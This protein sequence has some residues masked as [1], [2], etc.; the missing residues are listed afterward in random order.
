VVEVWPILVWPVV[1]PRRP[2]AKKL[3][4]NKKK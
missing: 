3:K 2:P 1:G 4:K